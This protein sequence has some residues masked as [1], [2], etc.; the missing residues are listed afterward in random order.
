MA[1]INYAKLRA[2]LKDGSAPVDPDARIGEIA[3]E[4]YYSEGSAG[5]I[6]RISKNDGLDD[7]I[8]DGPVRAALEDFYGEIEDDS[9]AV[10]VIYVKADTTGSNGAVVHV[11]TGSGAMVASGTGKWYVEPIVKVTTAGAAA[12]AQVAVSLDGGNS[13]KDPVTVEAGGAVVLHENLGLTGTFDI[14]DND[15]VENDTF[16]FDVTPDSMA[17]GD[18]ETADTIHYATQAYYDDEA[19]ALKAEAIF[20][21]GPVAASN[22]DDLQDLAEDRFDEFTPQVFVGDFRRI[23]W[24]TSETLTEY[25]NV[26]A[27]AFADA[28]AVAK[29]WFGWCMGYATRDVTFDNSISWKLPWSNIGITAGVMCRMNKISDST[30]ATT[31]AGDVNK[32]RSTVYSKQFTSS[33]TEALNELGATLLR[34]HKGSTFFW[35]T[36]MGTCAGAGNIY[37]PLDRVRVVT[38]AI[39]AVFAALFP[40]IDKDL[41]GDDASGMEP[42]VLSAKVNAECW[43]SLKTYLAKLTTKVTSSGDA[44]TCDINMQPRRKASI[45]DANLAMKETLTIARS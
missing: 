18:V 22:V 37:Q 24:S 38:Y 27:A 30:G 42:K 34:K 13:Y 8:G 15:L 29:R 14:G 28:N 36:R 31:N 1:G 26:C 16:A 41:D 40:Y 32:L 39:G 4:G 21:V 6:L 44:F 9:Y 20:I 43:E 35:L 5:E 3:F 10:T 11:G 17:F 45:I 19:F 23:D 12:T 7:Y 25:Y 33:Q 2:S